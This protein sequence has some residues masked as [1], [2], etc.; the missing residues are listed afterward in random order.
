[1]PRFSVRGMSGSVRVYFL[2]FSLTAL[3]SE[4]W[5]AKHSMAL[6]KGLLS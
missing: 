1:M 6:I 4:S 3:T 5:A 2:K